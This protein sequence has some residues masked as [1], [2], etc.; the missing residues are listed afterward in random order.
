MHISAYRDSFQ[1]LNCSHCPLL[2]LPS[3]YATSPTFCMPTDVYSCG[4]F[5]AEKRSAL[6]DDVVSGGFLDRHSL[7]HL[8]SHLECGQSQG[9]NPCKMV[10]A[11]TMVGK[12]VVCM[13]WGLPGQF[14]CSTCFSQRWETS[15]FEIKFVHKDKDPHIYSPWSLYLQTFLTNCWWFIIILAQFVSF[16]LLGATPPKNSQPTITKEDVLGS[17]LAILYVT[18][19]EEYQD[20]QGSEALETEPLAA[21][22]SDNLQ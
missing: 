12:V 4:V 15:G 21:E 9:G 22:T 13:S 5:L 17:H 16:F 7:W 8:Q 1:I 19:V 11:P 14:F 2:L 3:A 20:H 18:G 6:L 10:G